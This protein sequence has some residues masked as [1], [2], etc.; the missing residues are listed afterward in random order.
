MSTVTVIYEVK[1][2]V[3]FIKD[4]D[5][6][7]AKYIS[8]GNRTSVAKAYLVKEGRL[9]SIHGDLEREDDPSDLSNPE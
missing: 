1:D 8:F 6:K 2:P 5:L 3:E 4:L 9:E 7:R